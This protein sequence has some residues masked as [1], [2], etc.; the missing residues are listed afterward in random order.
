MSK[1]KRLFARFIILGLFLFA[2]LSIN[3]AYSANNTFVFNKNLTLGNVNNDVKELQKYLNNNG[4][5]LVNTGAGSPGKETTYFGSVT[6]K[7]LIKFQQT[8]NIQPSVGYFGPLTRN[9]IN[10]MNHLGNK[11]NG[12]N[13]DSNSNSNS[14]NNSNNNQANNTNNTSNNNSTGYTIGGSITGLG[15]PVTLQNNNGDDITINPGA[16]SEFI[17]PNKLNSNINYVVT[18]KQNYL[19]QV[20]FIKD[21]VGTVTNFDV[22]TVR[23]ACGLK[24]YFNPF[25]TITN[26]SS[27]IYTLSYAAGAN[28]YIEGSTS[29]NVS[30]GSSATTTIA[31]PSE[32][33]YF[34]Q[35]SDG[36]LTP[37]RTE[38]N[39]IADKSVTATFEVNSYTLT[40]KSDASGSIVGDS[41]QIVTYG[42]DGTEVEAIP[43]AGYVFVN[44]S[45]ESTANPRIDT[46]VKDDISVTANFEIISYTLNYV[47]GDNGSIN[48]EFSQKIDYGSDGTEV[49]AIPNEGYIFVNWSDES[50]DNPRTD[51]KI[52][53]NISVTANFELLKGPSFI[54]C[55]DDLTYEGETYPTIQIGAQCWLAKNLNVGVQVNNGSSGSDCYLIYSNKG[56]EYW[57]CQANNDAIE[58]YCYDDFGGNCTTDGG[59][60]EWAEALQL[61]YDCNKAMASMPLVG[62]GYNMSC[63]LSGTNHISP[64]QQGICPTD[65]HIPT[66]DEY[67]ILAQN[68]DAGCSLTGGTCSTAGTKLKADAGHLPIAWNGTDDYGFSAIPAGYRNN[69]IDPYMNHGF[70]NNFW[71]LDPTALSA[72]GGQGVFLNTGTTIFSTSAYRSSGYSVRCVKNP[73]RVK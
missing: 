36:V 4:F 69:N 44:W 17:F 67:Q 12:I 42:F 55:G 54:S 5:R 23:I 29:Q 48:G 64:L 61:P 71:S 66:L 32:G 27:P 70:E 10:L 20:C 28:G 43:S 34:V 30:H 31:V 45:D 46:K 57:S 37:E 18:I 26:S 38:T 24:L 68:A 58:K 51:T 14:N 62:G 72:V 59:L 25:T 8:N 47:A 35:W 39:V 60:Y 1:D 33:Y 9:F 21:N 65:W 15:G 50:T 73:D 13:N 19:G 6:K 41:I 16:S 63:P 22:S 53:S 3:S 52:K 40:Y 11:T 56:T 2:L 7:A 49:E